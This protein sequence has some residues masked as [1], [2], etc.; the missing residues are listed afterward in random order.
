MQAEAVVAAVTGDTLHSLESIADTAINRYGALQD[1]WEFTQLLHLARQRITGG[2]IVEIGCDR[3]G[4]LWAWRQFTQRV[5]AVTLHSRADRQFSAHGAALI[6]SDST[7]P[8]TADQ[9]E[10]LL[11]DD[12]PD[13]VFVD[14]G[15]DYATTLSDIRLACRIAPGGLVVVHDINRRQD[16]P[17]IE[18]WWVWAN[19]RDWYPSVEIRRTPGATPGTGIMFPGAAPAR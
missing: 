7:Q 13:L 6:I 10:V 11:G 8:A 1:H 2:T 14:G 3:G 18:T 15:H 16:A 5:V 12:T 17:E 9:L 4:T 19:C